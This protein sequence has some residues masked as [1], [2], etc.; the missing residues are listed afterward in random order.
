M[1]ANTTDESKKKTRQAHEVNLKRRIE[2][3]HER[4]KRTKKRNLLPSRLWNRK[5]PP[6]EHVD[7]HIQSLATHLVPG[8]N[9]PDVLIETVTSFRRLLMK[10]FRPP[11]EPVVQAGR[12]LDFIVTE[13]FRCLCIF[14][15]LFG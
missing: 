14:C 8:L 10:E 4:E 3:R 7:D 6:V 15:K 1:V 5:A 13:S 11:I 12:V 9:G 2:K